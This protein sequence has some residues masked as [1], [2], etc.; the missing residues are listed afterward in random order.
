MDDEGLTQFDRELLKQDAR[1]RNGQWRLSR[2]ISLANVITLVVIA[3]T[4]IGAYY[5]LSG[6]VTS[7]EQSIATQKHTDDRQDAEANRTEVRTQAALD[8]INRK[9]D[10][11]IER[12]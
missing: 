3:V 7:T 4:V 12:R 10:R 2:E 5:S 6:R 8:S 11:L 1:E 9:L